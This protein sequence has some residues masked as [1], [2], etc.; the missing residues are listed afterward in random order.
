MSDGKITLRSY[1]LAFELERRIHRIDRF[2]IPVP[3]GIP[4]AGLGYAAAIAVGLLVVGELPLIGA[5]VHVLPWPLRLVV[6]PGLATRALCHQRADGRPAHEA[7]VAACA[8]ALSAKQLV[9]LERRPS[10]AVEPATIPI[11]ADERGPLYT[12]GEV[13]GPATVLLRQPAAVDVRGRRARLRQLDDRLLAEPQE[14]RLE[15]GARLEIT[16]APR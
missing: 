3:Y 12:Q 6:L 5:L 15:A 4:L 9:A 1:R 10:R 7:L 13:V 16:C 14:L 2:R 8:F 11:A